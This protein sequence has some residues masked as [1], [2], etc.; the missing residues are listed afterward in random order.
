MLTLDQAKRLKEA[1]LTAYNHNIDTPESIMA[2]LY[3]RT[4][5]D[6]SNFKKCI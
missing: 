1:G 2:M 6:R 3:Q 5:D 4:F